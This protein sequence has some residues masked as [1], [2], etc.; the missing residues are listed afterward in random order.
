MAAHAG[1]TL[2][3]A[4]RDH[5]T[6]H[7]LKPPSAH[8]SVQGRLCRGCRAARCCALSHQ[9]IPL[10]VQGL[11]LTGILHYE[12]LCLCEQAHGNARGEA[13]GLG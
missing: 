2:S 9:S 1:V 3:T 7:T 10:H 4:R 12:S 13:K 8:P 11:L 6:M 5:A